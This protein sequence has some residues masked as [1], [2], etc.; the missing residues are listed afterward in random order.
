MLCFVDLSLTLTQT[1]ENFPFA[2]RMILELL[3]L[4]LIVPTCGFHQKLKYVVGLDLKPKRSFYDRYVLHQILICLCASIIQEFSICFTTLNLNRRW[5]TGLVNK[6]IDVDDLESFESNSFMD[7]AENKLV[8]SRESN[9]MRPS[10]ST[11]EFI[12]TKTGRF[13]C[14]LQPHLDY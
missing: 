3:H 7:H 4:K 9:R 5:T 12:S 11:E 10:C 13:S 8:S 1:Q 6:V 2:K 14:S